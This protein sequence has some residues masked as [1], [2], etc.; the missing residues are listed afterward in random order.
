MSPPQIYIVISIIVLA[1]IAS[2][3]FFVNKNKKDKKLTPLASYAFAFVLAGIIFGDNKLLGYTLMGTGVIL[4]I[5]DMIDTYKKS[6]K[7]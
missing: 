6:E 1:I 4:A 2:L 7:K 3:L 5:I